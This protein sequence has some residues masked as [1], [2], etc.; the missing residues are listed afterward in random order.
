MNNVY[1]IENHDMALEIWLNNGV[2]AGTLIHVDAH[3]DYVPSKDAHYINIGN[4]L[5]YAVLGKLFKKIYWVVPDIFWKDLGYTQIIIDQLPHCFEVI[6]INEKTIR[7]KNTEFPLVDFAIIGI[8]NTFA[9]MEEILDNDL[10]CVD[11]DIDYMMNP[12]VSQIY[13]YRYPSKSWCAAYELYS[14]L[15]PLI[16]K[17]DVVTIA[18][19]FYGGYTPLLHAYLSEYLYELFCDGMEK[20]CKNFKLLENGLDSLSID[21]YYEAVNCY[22]QVDGSFFTL[23][24]KQIGLLYSYVSTGNLYEAQ[25]VY[26]ILETHYKNYE[27]YYFP[28]SVLLFNKQLDL[29]KKML[30]YWLQVANLSEQAN[31]YFLKYI[32]CTEE[33]SNEFEI[34]KYASKITDLG[35]AYEK[36]YVLGNIY[37]QRLE[38]Q[39]SINLFNS[40]LA[41]LR[42]NCTPAWCGQI[43]SFEKHKNHGVITSHIYEKLMNAY[44]GLENYKMAKK[45]AMIC[46]KMGRVNSKIEQIL[47]C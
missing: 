41:F 26:S 46:K 13:S 8:S 7:L 29:A 9:N 3:F 11:I 36:S 43:S 12:T 38:Y 5:T 6:D 21:D 19:S 37:L 40:V 28:I 30:E 34:K 47:L 1:I 22:K 35:T 18:N 33:V 27:A 10:I 31:L 45:Y 42:H 24:S 15:A 2:C 23:L 25:K 16:K 32:S 4:Y 39:K 14:Q 17:I 44:I 20:K